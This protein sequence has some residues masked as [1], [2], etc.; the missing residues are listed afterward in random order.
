VKFACPECAARQDTREK[1]A[2]CGAEGLVDLSSV[3]ETEYLR[4]LDRERRDRYGNRARVGSAVVSMAIVIAIW[5]IPGFW[6]ARRQGFA[7]PLLIDQLLIMIA[8]AFVVMKVFDRYAP[9]TKFPYL[10]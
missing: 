7:L 10:D 6:A 2:A 4:K 9:K 1:C 5:F 3:R 8:V